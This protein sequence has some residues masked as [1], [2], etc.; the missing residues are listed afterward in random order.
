MEKIKKSNLF[1]D[2]KSKIKHFCSYQERCHQEVKNKLIKLNLSK[3]EIEKIIVY[4][5]ENNYLNESRFAKIF[6]GGKFRIKNWGKIRIIRELKNRKISDYNI[7]L[8][9]E[10]INHDDYIETFNLISNKKLDTLKSLNPIKR[11]EK[12]LAFLTYKGWEKEMIY[13]KLNSF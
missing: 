13:E 11:K 10:E 3:K 6:A 9:L 2:T 12:L 1:I 4:L 5:I 8:A 7:K